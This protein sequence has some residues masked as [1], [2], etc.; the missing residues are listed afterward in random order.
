MF[1]IVVFEKVEIVVSQ[2]R[3]KYSNCPKKLLIGFIRDIL[4]R[5]AQVFF[6]AFTIVRK[7]V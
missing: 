2:K 3:L 7:I 1:F 4:I 5:S 6:K